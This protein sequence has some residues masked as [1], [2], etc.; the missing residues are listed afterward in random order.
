LALRGE[1]QAD[2]AEKFGITQ[3][4]V[5]QLK[6]AK[7]DEIRNRYRQGRWHENHNFRYTVGKK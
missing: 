1:K 5:S 2:I 7:I 4:R 6:A 3:G